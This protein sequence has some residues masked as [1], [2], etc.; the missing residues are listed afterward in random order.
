[1][2][3]ATFGNEEETQLKLDNDNDDDSDARFDRRTFERTENAFP[4]AAVLEPRT[5]NSINF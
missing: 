2:Y 1:M 4:T 3:L 5:A